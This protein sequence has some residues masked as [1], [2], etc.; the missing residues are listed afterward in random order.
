MTKNSDIIDLENGFTRNQSYTSTAITHSKTKMTINELKAFYQ[1]STLIKKDDT[2]FLRYS[3]RVNDFVEKLG[4]TK[5]NNDYIKD[6]CRCL[7][8]QTFEIEKDGIWDIY[9]IFSSFRFD[10]KNQIIT[11]CF[12]DE[13]RPYLLE[14]KSN[15]TEIKEIKYIRQ[16]ESKY[17]IRI[18]T[19]LKDY[20]L[21][22]SREFNIEKLTEILQLPKSYRDFSYFNQRVLKPAISEINAKSDLKIVNLKRVKTGRKITSI[23][24]YFQRKEQAKAKTLNARATKR[25]NQK[26]KKEI[27]DQEFSNQFYGQKIKING[28]TFQIYKIFQNQDKTITANLEDFSKLSYGLTQPYKFENLE[29]LRGL[30]AEYELNNQK[31]DKSQEVFKKFEKLAQ[32]KK[33]KK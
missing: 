14:L 13:M 11:M 10:T 20:R 16:F 29:T 18:Y 19:M 21:M 22:D 12:N 25:Q 17:A 30:I 7:A 6:L 24:I 2:E 23:I 27:A 31:S 4:F 3:I 8:K 26:T 32:K 9:T 5:T 33:L 15:F 1:V 28:I